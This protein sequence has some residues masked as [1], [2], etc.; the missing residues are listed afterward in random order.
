[1]IDSLVVKKKDARKF[2]LAL[3][4]VLI[5][6][7]LTSGFSQKPI[8]LCLRILVGM[9][10]SYCIFKGLKEPVL[11]NP[12]LLFSLTPISLLLY[13]ETVSR[14][15][16]MKLETATWGIAIINFLSFLFVFS[17]HKPKLKKQLINEVGTGSL[18]NSTT[19]FTI[20]LAIGAFPLL[21][22][23]VMGKTFFLASIISYFIYGALCVAVKTKRK[24]LGIIACM[25]F[26]FSFTQR[27]NKTM[28]IALGMT[29]IIAVEKYW[30]LTDKQ[31]KKMILGIVFFAGIM[32]GIGFPLK[33][34]MARGGSLIGFFRGVTVTSDF[35]GYGNRIDIG[36]LN[37]LR[38][39]YMYF[40][41][42]W[43]NLQYVM[44]TQTDHTFGLWMIKP[45]LGYLQLDQ[46]FKN[47]YTL[48]PYSSFN[49][50]TYI[51]VLFKDFGFVGSTV[52]SFFLGWFVKKMY[53]LYLHSKSS[54]WV[55]C[56]A[57]T[58]CATVE[59]F[60]SNHF[61]SLSYPFTIYIISYMYRFVFIS[62]KNYKGV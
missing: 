58:A 1:M 2:I 19:H 59:M 26:L 27:F 49:T 43:N 32:F 48:T 10:A 12:Y 62:L 47:A 37:F 13:T 44:Q 57:M 23:T 55:A 52:G 41:S 9:T 29:I 14:V 38:M 7:Y 61:F 46:F 60:F 20:L 30:I 40:V 45:V 16:L 24:E 5:L 22:K 31:K 36:K 18:K 25:Y 28:L 42:A 39:P 8:D 33:D 54:L 53:T 15:Y 56:Y 11:V 34:Y 3:V 50:Y 51:T 6:I 35:A 4:S 17:L 21:Y